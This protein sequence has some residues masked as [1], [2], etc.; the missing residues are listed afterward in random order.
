MRS[1]QSPSLRR[2]RI[3]DEG[4]ASADVRLDFQPADHLRLRSGM[5]VRSRVN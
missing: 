2:A 1:R 5:S 4:S 3:S